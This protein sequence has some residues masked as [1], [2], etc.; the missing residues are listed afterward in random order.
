MKE[1]LNIESSSRDKLGYTQS[2]GINVRDK[3]DEDNDTVR[4]DI[5]W[6]ISTQD[7]EEANHGE[8]VQNGQIN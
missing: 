1:N 4:E 6:V 7:K 5:P 8:L 2:E 3:S